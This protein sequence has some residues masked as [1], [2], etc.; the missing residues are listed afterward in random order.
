MPGKTDQVL[1]LASVTREER[2]DWDRFLAKMAALFREARC[3]DRDRVVCLADYLDHVS[4]DRVT[5]DEAPVV[6]A[7]T[8]RLLD[9]LG[10]GDADVSYNLAQGGGGRAVP[11]FTVRVHDVLGMTPVFV[12]E[13]KATSERDFS[14]PRHGGADGGETPLD[15]L[16][17]YVRGGAVF[18]RVGLLCNGFV[19]EAWEFASDQETRLAR[20]DLHELAR[21]A[22]DGGFPGPQE[23]GLKVVWSRFSRF[24]FA[25]TW[26][27]ASARVRPP[28]LETETIA[29]LN[30]ALAQDG[31]EGFE[32]VLHAH[33]EQHWKARAIDVSRHVDALVQ[34]LRGLID[35]FSDDVAVQVQDA[36]DRSRAYHEAEADLDTRMDLESL[37]G[38]LAAD[39]RAVFVPGA[40]Q[41]LLEEPL[42]AWARAPRIDRLQERVRE[43]VDALKEHVAPVAEMPQ[44]E[45]QA[46][47]GIG[48][49]H[50]VGG[51]RALR[52]RLDVLR[53]DVEKYCR[54]VL[55]RHARQAELV[56]T[57]R[58]GLRVAASF[59]AWARRVST[60][61]M[62]GATHEVLV[63][64]FSRQTAYVYVI[65]LLL[66]RICEDK[67]LFRRKLSDGGLVHWQE[68][69][70]RYLDYASGRSYEYL[71]KMA[72]ECAQ[73][74][75]THFYGASAPFDGYRMD[76]KMLLRAL[77]VLDAFDL[78]RIDADIIGTVY[79]QYLTEGKHEQ[80]RYY[81][82]HAL[83]VEMLDRMGFGGEATFGRRIADLACGSGSFLVEA[84]RRILD[85][86]RGSDGTIPAAQASAALD[87]VQRSVYGFDLNPFA[88]YLAETNLLIQVLDLVR[89]AQRHDQ[90]LVV[91]RFHIYCADSL[92][93]DEAVAAAPESAILVG[94]DRAVAEL[95]KAR[96][97][98]FAGG[99]DFLIGN[100]P[101]VRADEESETWQQYRRLLE[102]QSWF[103][104]R[105]L[106]W[107]LYVPFVE[108]YWRLLSDDPQARACLVT[109]ESLGTAPYAARLRELLARQATLT[110]VV[111][112]RGL[113]LFPDAAWQDNL[114]FVFRRGAPPTAHEV[115]RQAWRR[116]EDGGT[117]FEPL[118]RIVQVEATPE[119]LF[120]DRG[121]IDLDLRGTVPLEALCYV[122]VGMVLNSDEKL[123]E[124]QI[125]LVPEVYDPEAFGEE[126][127]E[128]LG[129][130]GKRIRHRH[131]KREE[132]VGEV[133]DAIHTRPFL[134]SREVLRGGIGRIRWLEYGSHTRCPAR[135]RRRTFPE[136]Y[137]RPKLMFGTFTG[138]AV[139]EGD[140]QG[141][142]V[143]S[144][145]V[146]LA[147]RWSLLE[148]V[149]NQTL[150]EA[151]A[152]A[153]KRI[154][155]NTDLSTN[156]SEWYL[157]A[158]T[159]STPI[160]RW[161][162][163]HK[164]SM[165]DHV[166]PDDIKAI[167]IKLLPPERQQPFIDLARERHRLWDEVVAREAD[168]YRGTESVKVPVRRLVEGFAAEHADLTFVTLAEAQP[169]GLLRWEAD[170]FGHDLAKVR[171]SGNTLRVGTNVIARAGDSLTDGVGVLKVLARVMAAFPGP[172]ATV[173][174]ICRI[175][176]T[177]EGV[178]AL[179]AF[180]DAEAAAQEARHR[181][182]AQIGAEID[183]MAWALYRPGASRG[184]E[185]PAGAV[186]F[187]ALGG[188][189]EQGVREIQGT[190]L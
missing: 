63:A 1:E 159:L 37:R 7:Y 163:V 187:P 181:R 143:T 33:Y 145:S 129:K 22:R 64:E 48:K 53:D 114:I 108:Q 100:P 190:L 117:A 105:H 20:L 154:R 35:L 18:G 74:V 3:P 61:V 122:S 82:P 28:R 45:Q 77:L 178:L 15:Q 60:T 27:L 116:K 58:P 179:G 115:V 137:D 95:A 161:L 80:G 147:I 21:L 11:D 50:A 168:G 98:P 47:T 55:E 141:F 121:P 164:R 25:T 177:Q 97:G 175:P 140:G 146:R 113:R 88:C 102:Q 75:Y 180:L 14:R 65:R 155:L 128:D 84:C 131:F 69:V 79:G 34:A 120:T 76:D 162:H 148:E 85:G 86:F 158:L 103:A 112:T 96:T 183:E 151:R 127:V 107:D 123:A 169:V 153:R 19:L 125:V 83:V 142:L 186:A 30:E 68:Q 133:Q 67:G 78:E 170:A 182:I 91:D 165:K 138:V 92:M 70:G 134:G 172:L 160:Q 152:E 136:L 101:Y 66:V 10:Y 71:T 16:R 17:R 62:V 132:L 9:A 144:D 176:R 39:W 72:Y 90:S 124:G 32:R 173:Q 24:S 139:D 126:L 149:N 104:T 59:E 185:D 6:D 51:P 81:T 42:D 111:L 12:V 171:A 23:A 150:R 40:F 189:G 156:L 54:R 87:A 4:K 89:E 135:I 31:K 52:T 26:S 174:A 157:A 41:E 46:F 130:G 166:Y 93:V 49:A 2:A 57:H 44:G 5:G 29:R 167:P 94:K 36:I 110:D 119:K 188:T 43:W 106:K 8:R 73:N 56:A 13:D 184:T 99:F 118:D 109:I 38:R